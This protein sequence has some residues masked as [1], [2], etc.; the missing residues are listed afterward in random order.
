LQAKLYDAESTALPKQSFT[1][2]ATSFGSVH[3]TLL[4][5]GRELTSAFIYT[6]A[7]PED[8]ITAR[9]RWRQGDGTWQK[10]E[11]DVYPYEFSP[12]IRDEAGNF[13]ALFEIEDVNQQWHRSPVITLAVNTSS[14]PLPTTASPSSETLKTQKSALS[15]LTSS[16]PPIL[17]DEFI[18]YLQHAANGDNFGFRADGRFYPYSTPQGRRIAW[19]QPVWDKRFFAEGCTREEADR[20]LRAELSRTASHRLR[21]T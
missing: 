13:E 19:R 3:A 10:M 15:D 2:V 1:T 4:R 20:Q 7:L 6:E 21:H 9:L 11:D 5:A 18:A 12:E 17:T 8:V 16:S 14:K